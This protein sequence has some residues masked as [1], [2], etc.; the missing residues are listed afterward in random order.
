MPCVCECLSHFSSN[1]IGQLNHNYCF[2]FNCLGLHFFMLFSIQKNML[3]SI[4]KNM[5]SSIDKNIEVVF[6]F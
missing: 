1:V 6:H 5:S 2:N 4:Q 3:S